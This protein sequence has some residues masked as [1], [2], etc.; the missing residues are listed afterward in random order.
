MYWNIPVSPS[1]PT[2]NIIPSS[3][4]IVLK[5]IEPITKSTVSCGSRIPTE[6]KTMI[7]INAPSNAS[8]VL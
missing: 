6:N 3:N 2:I 5:S 4:P 1:I 7:I 8:D